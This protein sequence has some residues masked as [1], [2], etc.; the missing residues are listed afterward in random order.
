LLAGC[1]TE[2]S[3]GATDSL[4]ASL[5]ATD[6]NVQ[7]AGV[8]VSELRGRRV[9]GPQRPFIA[10][11]RRSKAVRARRGAVADPP[12]EDPRRAGTR[13]HLR[14]V[15]GAGAVWRGRDPRRREADGRRATARGGLR[16]AV[17]RA[18]SRGA[19]SRAAPSPKPAALVLPPRLAWCHSTKSLTGPAIHLRVKAL[20]ITFL[21]PYSLGPFRSYSYSLSPPPRS[22]Y[23]PSRAR[24]AAGP[25]GHGA[26][27]PQSL[28][29]PTHRQY[30]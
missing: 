15:A 26:Q 11:I 13:Q 28:T 22:S 14:G 3:S 25:H 20:S 29:V 19:A 12:A 5:T 9:A 18:A 24:A 4:T 10:G 27:S 7:R 8:S 17:S 2:R 21:S 16:S 23:H 1:H 30:D 6:L